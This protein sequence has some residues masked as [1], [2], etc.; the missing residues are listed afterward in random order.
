MNA[1][2]ERA[3]P[4]YETHPGWSEDITGCRKF[5]DLPTAARNYVLRIEQLVERPIHYVSVG[6]GREQMVLR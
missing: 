3:A 1:V 4:V 2:L 5:S 6:P